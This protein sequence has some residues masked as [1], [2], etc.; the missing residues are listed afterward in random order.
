ML[1]LLG[2]TFNEEDLPKKYCSMSRCYRAEG[3]STK[4]N[5][6]LYRV[7]YFNKVEMFAITDERQSPQML[8]HLVDI[9]KTLFER[10]SL[11]FKV[12]DMPPHDLGVPAFRKFDIEAY[13]SGIS[14]LLI[15]VLIF[16]I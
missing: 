9:Q 2:E 1:L 14:L 16:Y 7:H 5:W 13:M 8:D 15:I 6:G 10:L 3:K 11:C 12:V 4:Q